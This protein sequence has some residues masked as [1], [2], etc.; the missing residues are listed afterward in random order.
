MFMHGIRFAPPAR[1]RSTALLQYFGVRKSYKYAHG[2]LDGMAHET[3]Q[4]SESREQR[5][6]KKLVG[7]LAVLGVDGVAVP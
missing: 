2:I 5:P 7:C 3:E 4:G 1:S 6:G